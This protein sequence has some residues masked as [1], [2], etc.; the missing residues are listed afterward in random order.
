[1]PV[2]GI[3]GSGSSS[4]F[5]DLLIAFRQ[6]LKETGYAEGQNVAIESRWAEGQFVRLSDLA[7][8]LVH[9]RAALTGQVDFDVLRASAG[10]SDRPWHRDGAPRHTRIMPDK[11]PKRPHDLAQLAKPAKPSNSRRRSRK[12]EN[13]ADAL[14]RLR[15]GDKV[16]LVFSDVVMPGDMNGIALAQEIA[17][18]YPQIRNHALDQLDIAAA[19][20][21]T[22]LRAACCDCCPLCHTRCT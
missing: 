16:D 6:G 3:L 22:R 14:N 7:A 9:R 21:R 2:I 8:D 18:H 12:A 17:N 19:R 5:A 1:M 13:A 10:R 4:A 11:R 20:S 15:R